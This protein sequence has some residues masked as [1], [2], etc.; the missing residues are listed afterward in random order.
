MSQEDLRQRLEAKQ[1][2]ITPQRLVIL[3][4]LLSTDTHPTADEVYQVVEQRLPAISRA[5]VYNTLNALADA[6]LVRT[7]STQPGVTR[8]D[9]NPSAHHH[10]VDIK[11]G[12]IHDIPWSQ[13]DQLCQSLGPDF[14]VHDYQITFY[15]QHTSTAAAC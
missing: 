8:Y 13:V 14:T 7:V 12:R 9:G 4:Y 6:G 15:G 2:K 10:F 5:T 1:L 3:D 11:T